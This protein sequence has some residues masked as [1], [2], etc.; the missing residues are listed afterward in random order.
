MSKQVDLKLLR[1]SACIC[2]LL[3]YQFTYNII[4]LTVFNFWEG[5]IM[6]IIDLNEMEIEQIENRLAAFDEKYITYKMDGSIQI[7]IQE[8]GKIVAG[9]DACI[10][11]FKILYV[12]TLFVDEEYRRKG[13]GRILMEE[14][15]KRAKKM[16]VNTIRLDTF[17]W[18]GKEFYESLDY[19][20]VGSYENIDDGY[21]EYFFLK[22]I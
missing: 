19:E 9:L 8:D 11:A 14:M 1:T 6:K 2:F 16:G 4:H 20:I 22:K 5:Y 15:E 18:Q 7:G 17:S 10:T 3:N 13:Y 21:A 12:S